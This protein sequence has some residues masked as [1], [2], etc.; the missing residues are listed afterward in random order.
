ML[1]IWKLNAFQN[2]EWSMQ[3]EELYPLPPQVM[4]GIS[5]YLYIF[6]CVCACV[7]V[8]EKRSDRNVLTLMMTIII[9]IK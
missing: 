4:L 1:K 9:I 3:L 8:I 7:R 6:I 2:K 5:V